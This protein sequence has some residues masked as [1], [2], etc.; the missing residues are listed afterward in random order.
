MG[1]DPAELGEGLAE[2]RRY[3]LSHHE[4]EEWYRCYAPVVF[5]R[6]IRL[7]A[8]C[9]GV[10]PGIALGVLAYFLA[11][12]AVTG[13][14]VVAAVPAPALVDWTVTT[15]TDRRGTN[16]VRTATGAALGYGY[17]LGVARLLF[18]AALPVVAVGAVYA[19][20]AGTLLYVN[21]E[22]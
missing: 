21:D 10:Y 6:R 18:E 15:F 11:P 13:L 19:V 4:P 1:L 7:C 12:G 17:G 8:R 5:G 2:T 14:A 9:T 16:P 22:Y 20:A 3:V